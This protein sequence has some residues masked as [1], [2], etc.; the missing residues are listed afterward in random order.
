MT[1]WYKEVPDDQRISY[2]VTPLPG[3]LMRADLIGGQLRALARLMRACADEPK[4]GI[5]M[6]VFVGGIRMD[7]GGSIHF[8]LAVLPK[9]E[10]DE[11]QEQ[12]APTP[13]KQE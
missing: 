8:D 3:A 11:E 12:N 9:I 2:S 5:Q 6:E 7:E 1:M 4:S 13:S 10:S